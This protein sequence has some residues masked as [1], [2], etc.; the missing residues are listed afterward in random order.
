MWPAVCDGVTNAVTPVAFEVNTAYVSNETGGS[1]TVAP[2]MPIDIKPEAAVGLG[3]GS[4]GTGGATPQ[5]GIVG[6]ALAKLAG[7]SGGAAGKL[8]AAE[9]AAVKAFAD[10]NTE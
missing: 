9:A 2:S 1:E 5:S 6:D 10:G 4:A 7:M 8:T 3:G